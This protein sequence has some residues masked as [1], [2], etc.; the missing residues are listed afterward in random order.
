MSDRSGFLS[1]IRNVRS[2]NRLLC[3]GF[4]R[5]LSALLDQELPEDAARRTLIGAPF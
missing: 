3:A 4:Q 2:S 1:A 5:D